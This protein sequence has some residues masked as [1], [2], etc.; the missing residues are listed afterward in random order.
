VECAIRPERHPGREEEVIAPPAAPPAQRGQ[1]A[2]SGAPRT[3]SAATTT[4]LA[5]AT[6]LSSPPPDPDPASAFWPLTN[7]PAPDPSPGPLAAL[8]SQGRC[9]GGLD[10]Q[11]RPRLVFRRVRRPT[12]AAPSRRNEV[13]TG[14]GRN[15]RPQ[16]N[17]GRNTPT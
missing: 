7:W 13:R 17:E 4:A 2:C 9:P 3:A 5:G 12:G 8:G 11:R 10:A 15:R 6:S 16:Q 14:L 1:P